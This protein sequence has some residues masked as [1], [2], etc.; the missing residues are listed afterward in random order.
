MVHVVL[1]SCALLMCLL[2][3]T[4]HMQCLRSLRLTRRMVHVALC[5][6]ALL[7]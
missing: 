3:C 7:M 4:V 1:C 5:S 2:C 6:C